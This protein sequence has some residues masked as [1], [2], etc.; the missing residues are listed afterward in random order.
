MGGLNRKDVKH[1]MLISGR[2]HP[3]LAQEIAEILDTTIVPTRMVTYANSEIYV[4]YEKTVRGCDAF[5]LQ[6]HVGQLGDYS[7]NDYLMEQLIMI[8][9]L[10]RAS[11][12]RIIVVTPFYPYA[13]QDKKH[14][15][16]E[17]VS[18]RLVA[19]LFATAGAKR[20]MTVDLHASQ[21]QGFFNGPVDHLW[22]LPIL[23]DYTRSRVDLRNVT[24][25]SPDAGRIRV[26]ELWS[27]KLGGCPLAFV[28]KTRDVTRANSAHANR[29]IG[30]VAGMDCIIVDDLI[31]T[32][33]TMSEA[34]K[35]VLEAGAKSVIV[36]A[37]HAPLSAPATQRL[38]ESGASE[39]IVT[40][41]LPI[42]AGKRFDELTVLSIA[43]VLATAMREVFDHGSVTSLFDG[44]S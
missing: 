41:T 26:A 16:R 17:P 13:R 11:A 10:R 15:G 35:V 9:A 34:V 39:I 28:H 20:I 1:L 21:I 3:G 32:G 19:D 12:K 43:P 27:A 30:D 2:S 14:A 25:V 38:H 7:V 23:V 42:E 18:A 36:T 8:D 5:V 22:A 40:D 29:V 24:V 33:G 6:A 37:T 44:N 31:D 4:R